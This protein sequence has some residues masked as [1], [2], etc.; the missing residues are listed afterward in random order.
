[1]LISIKKYTMIYHKNS[2]YY[3]VMMNMALWYFMMTM[4][5]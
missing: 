4:C 3:D 5:H 2:M 1:M